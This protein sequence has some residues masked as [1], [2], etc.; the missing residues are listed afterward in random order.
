MSKRTAFSV[1]ID[2]L[3]NWINKIEFNFETEDKEKEEKAVEV[4]P[5]RRAGR[6]KKTVS[7]G[8]PE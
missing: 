2:K 6:M 8:E 4:K 5:P 7:E 1:F 3:G